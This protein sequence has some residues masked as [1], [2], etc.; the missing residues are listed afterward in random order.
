MPVSAGQ[1]F[2]V[3]Q[4]MRPNESMPLT[5]KVFDAAR[6]ASASHVMSSTSS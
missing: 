4:D 2:A 1:S 6:S 3:S 5:P